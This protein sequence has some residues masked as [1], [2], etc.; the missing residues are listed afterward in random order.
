MINGQHRPAPACRFDHR[1]GFGRVGGHGFFDQDMDAALECRDGN[2]GMGV[3]RGQHVDH[4]G[5]LGVEQ[6]ADAIVYP[7]N[8]VAV[9]QIVD[10]GQGQVGH[11]HYIGA[12]GTDVGQMRIGNHPATSDPDLELRFRRHML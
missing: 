4:I 9:G 10:R 1:I 11:A 8:L 5:C 3:R 12:S 7:L 6:S 2:T